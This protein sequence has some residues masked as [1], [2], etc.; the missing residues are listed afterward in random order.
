MA[1]MGET[2][3]RQEPRTRLDARPRPVSSSAR[4]EGRTS[5]LAFPFPVEPSAEPRIRVGGAD[6]LRVQES[7]NVMVWTAVIFSPQAS[8]RRRGEA[9][10]EWANR[11][12]FGK[13]WGIE[14]GG[15]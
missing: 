10:E 11:D 2:A 8:R 15:V 7:S 3:G 9:I 4:G 1:E 5:C 12:R 13:T 14:T 6:L